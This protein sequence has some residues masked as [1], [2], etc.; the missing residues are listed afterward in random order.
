MPPLIRLLNVE[1][2]ATQREAAWAVSNVTMMGKPEH[3]EYMV[4]CNVVPSLCILLKS[5]DTQKLQVT[6]E[7]ILNILQKMPDHTDK[8]CQQIEENGGLDRIESLQVN[9][10]S[11]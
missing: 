9:R 4:N 2:F 7:A 1:N 6:L 10:L 11:F 3:I 5:E 8:L